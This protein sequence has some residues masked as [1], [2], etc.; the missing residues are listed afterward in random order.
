MEFEEIIVELVLGV[1]LLFIAFQIGYKGNIQLLHSYHYT[2]LNLNNKKK[3]TKK[4]GI[5]T[6]L[7][8]IGC[9]L[10]PI[11]NLIFH[12]DAGYYTGAIFMIIGTIYMVFI[13]I[14]YNGS[15]FSFKRK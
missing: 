1:F 11:I 8:G 2:N 4:M 12:F 10:M 6:M 7:V 13:V 5:G 14:K 15:L 3:F 9:I